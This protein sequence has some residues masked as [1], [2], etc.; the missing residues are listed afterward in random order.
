M[1]RWLATAHFEARRGPASAARDYCMKEDTRVDGPWERGIYGGNQGQR[2]DLEDVKT[3]IKAGATKSDLMEEHSEVMAKYPRFCMEYL[4]GHR[5]ASVQKLPSPLVPM[6]GWQQSVLDLV[7]GDV[8][9][10]HIHW[11]YDESGNH[12]KTYMGKY[13]VDHHNAFYSNG[14]KAVDL[15]YAYDGQPVVVFDFVRDA[16]EYVGYGVIEQLKNG[17]LFSPKYESGLKRFDIPHVFVFS[18]FR[19]AEGKF[20]SDRLQILE[21]NNDG[22]V[23]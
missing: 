16:Q 18:N 12:G 6:Y 7:S 21:I 17:I 11:V 23:V 10:R 2:S 5:E 14:G 9:A 4:K 1:R 13:L 3:A 8:H 19:P 15:T 22:N 20:S